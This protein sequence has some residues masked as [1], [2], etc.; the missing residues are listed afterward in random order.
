MI[1][2]LSIF[3]KDLYDE[4]WS[5]GMTKAAKKL[6]I[7]YH[8]LKKACVDYDIPLPTQ[9]YWSQLYMGNEKPSQPKLPNAE[10]NVV[11][12]I[13]KAKK[14]QVKLAPIRK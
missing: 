12:T 2:L 3:R 1:Y 4:V 9:S 14:N 6:D 5:V 10:D 8:N 13:K 7:P 11:I